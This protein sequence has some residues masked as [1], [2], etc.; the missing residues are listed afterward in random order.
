[1]PFTRPQ[2]GKFRPLVEK[3]WQT[4]AR[5]SCVDPKDAKSRRSWYESQLL[6]SVGVISTQALGPG[7][8]FDVLM[9]HFEALADNGETYWQHRTENGDFRRILWNVFKTDRPEIDGQPVD[10]HYLRSIAQQMLRLDAPP[11]LRTL[12]KSELNAVTRALAIHA[13]RRSKTG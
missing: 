13:R 11:F 12:K 1:M 5:L 4:H 9:A 8:D 6:A 10:I 7:R 2:Q 3:A